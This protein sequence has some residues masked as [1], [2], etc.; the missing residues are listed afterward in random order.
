MHSLGIGTMHEMNSVI[1]GLFIPSLTCRDYTL[2][3]KINLWR[4]KSQSGVSSLW[5]EMLATSLVDK[6][7]ELKIPIYFLEGIYDFT[8]SYQLAKEYYEKIRA[9]L[10]G[11]YTF[12]KSAHSPLFEEPEKMQQI[13]REDV[14][15]GENNLADVFAGN[16]G[17]QL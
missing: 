11:F 5:N 4:D 8:V 14:L 2:Q 10:K 16:P 1:S 6:V 13:M 3:E 9:P 7:S 12:E 17:K 15:R